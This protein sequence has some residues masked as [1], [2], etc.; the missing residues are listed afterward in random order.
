MDIP[1]VKA[2]ERDIRHDAD[3]RPAAGPEPG[4]GADVD[5]L[6][7]WWQL[8]TAAGHPAAQQ[9]VHRRDSDGPSLRLLWILTDCY[10]G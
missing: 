7:S 9:D 3:A 8:P 6:L 1:S 2:P 10:R 4:H 5:S